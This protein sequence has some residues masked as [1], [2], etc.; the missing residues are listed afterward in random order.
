MID[1]QG[2]RGYKTLVLFWN[3]GCGFCSRMVDD[4]KSW[5]ANPPASA[6]QLVLVSTGS[7]E[8]NQELGLAS[9]TLLDD[10]FN[11]GRAFGASG[12]PSAVLIDKNGKIASDVGVGAP[13]VLRLAGA[14]Q[15][16]EQAASV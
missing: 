9:V 13:E 8:P 7:V 15:A 11:T 1:L 12:T 16:P 3:P 4:L 6:P 14:T 5:E 10:G 2:F